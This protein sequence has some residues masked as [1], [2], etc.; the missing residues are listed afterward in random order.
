MLALQ[1]STTR[2]LNG[3]TLIV[4]LNLSV[5]LKAL[6]VRH[7]TYVLGPGG[8]QAGD[9]ACSPADAGVDGSLTTFAHRITDGVLTVALPDDHIRLTLRDVV[10]IPAPWF[11][12]QAQ[13]QLESDDGFSHHAENH[14]GKFWRRPHLT[15]GSPQPGACRSE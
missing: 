11:N 14:H 8:T 9:T 12:N 13:R 7:P 15:E 4:A 2:Q 6:T 3:D 5:K 10:A 1:L